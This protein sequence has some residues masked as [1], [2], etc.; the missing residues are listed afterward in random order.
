MCRILGLSAFVATILALLPLQVRAQD[1]GT[2]ADIR[3]VIVGVS[4]AGMAD[5][6]RQSAGMMLS[7]YYI[8]RLNG[9][10]PKLDIED[11]LIKE[12]NAMTPS[13][14]ASEAKRCGASLTDKGRE[15]TRIG[16]DISARGQ[17][18]NTDPK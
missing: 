15:I 10:V 6:S 14:Y 3:C 13:D 5:Q 17:K 18:S 8:G 12:M 9:R 2:I 7:L 16:Q 11:L 1:A 4:F